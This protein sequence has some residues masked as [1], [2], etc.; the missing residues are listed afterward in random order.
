[1]DNFG[2]ITY[3]CRII[4]PIKT[5][6]GFITLK[7]SQG[8]CDVKE[9]YQGKPQFINLLWSMNDLHGSLRNIWIKK[10]IKIRNETGRIIPTY[11]RKLERS[12]GSAFKNDVSPSSS[13][14]ARYAMKIA[15]ITGSIKKDRLSLP[16]YRWNFFKTR[17][18]TMNLSTKKTDENMCDFVWESIKSG[19][20]GAVNQY[21]ENEN[22][23]F[24]LHFNKK[25]VK[26]H[27]KIFDI[28]GTYLK[29]EKEEY[30]DRYEKQYEKNILIRE[31]RSLK[32][33]KFT[34]K[35]F[36]ITNFKANTTSEK[37]QFINGFWC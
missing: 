8:F 3:W 23:N 29:Y 32:K 1:M 33:K 4:N 7:N 17:R 26:I 25:R 10:I 11:F 36:Q 20:V 16:S 15:K 2:K 30:E 14:Y 9:N 35:K 19:E 6:K 12:I 31:S 22:T 28:I 5:S 24:F 37:G 27:G 18:K 34:N 13:I 21:F